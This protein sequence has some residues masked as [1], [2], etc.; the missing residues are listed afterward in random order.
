MNHHV[1]Y[2]GQSLRGHVL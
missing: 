1:K 2:L